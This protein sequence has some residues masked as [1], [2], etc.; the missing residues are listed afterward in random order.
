[1]IKWNPFSHGSKNYELTHLWPE[2]WVYTQEAKGDKLAIVYNIQII[3]SLH[4]FTKKKELDADATLDYSDTRETRTFCFD[5]YDY[6]F[7][8]PEI[9][10][11]LEK[12]YVYHT[13]KKNFMRIDKDE[14]EEYEVFFVVNK[15]K[16]AGIDIQLYINSA[17]LRTRGKSPKAGKIKFSVVAFNTMNNKPIKVYRR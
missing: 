15:S 16:L 17:Y 6:S 10:R 9:L 1:M 2:I 4:C 12:G 5:R 11:R 8:L 7:L 3:Y 13:G 14:N